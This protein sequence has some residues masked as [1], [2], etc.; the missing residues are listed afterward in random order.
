MEVLREKSGIQALLLVLLTVVLGLLSA[1]FLKEAAQKEGVTLAVLTGTI[2]V[3][4]GVNAGR[5]LL[6][7]YIHRHYPISVSYPLNSAFFPLILLM[8]YYYGEVVSVNEIIGV[9]L[10]TLGVGMLTYRYTP[11]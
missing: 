4:A 6:W 7:G 2:V 1:F 8:G 5:F 3:V 11:D 9:A 10:I